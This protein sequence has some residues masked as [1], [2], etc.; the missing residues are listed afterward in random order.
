MPCCPLHVHEEK[1]FSM[2]LRLDHGSCTWHGHKWV[3]LGTV[4]KQT[5]FG[6][7]TESRWQHVASR[8][9]SAFFC[10]NHRPYTNLFGHDASLFRASWVSQ[11]MVVARDVGWIRFRC[12]PT[13]WYLWLGDVNTLFTRQYGWCGASG[14]F[15]LCLWYVVARVGCTIDATDFHPIAE[16]VVVKQVSKWFVWVGL[17]LEQSQMVATNS[18][19]CT[20]CVIML[21]DHRIIFY[22]YPHHLTINIFYVCTPFAPI[23]Q[24]A[25]AEPNTYGNQHVLE[26]DTFTV[27]FVLFVCCLR[28]LATTAWHYFLIWKCNHNFYCSFRSDV[29]RVPHRKYVAQQWMIFRSSR[30][31]SKEVM[32]QLIAQGKSNF[33]REKAWKCLGMNRTLFIIILHYTIWCLIVKHSISSLACML[34][35]A[36]LASSEACAVNVSWMISAI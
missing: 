10:R 7:G 20:V 26:T 27:R 11:V 22:M 18:L 25:E 30:V 1:I 4:S 14:V 17:I 29:S 3:R 23:S 2:E 36:A 28:W 16:P 15:W 6:T 24:S 34:E 12:S 31:C 33:L 19:H 9:G 35:V 8:S 21:T 32:V 13:P 5:A